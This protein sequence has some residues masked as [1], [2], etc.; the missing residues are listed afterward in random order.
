MRLG[1]IYKI[2]EYK[3]KLEREY[4]LS[5]NTKDTRSASFKLVPTNPQV[6]TLLASLNLKVILIYVLHI[7]TT[8]KESYSGQISPNLII[9]TENS[10]AVAGAADETIPVSIS[11]EILYCFCLHFAALICA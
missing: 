2:F 9:F 8:P 6:K 5:P 10:F 7:F 3:H 11:T 1:L 4:V